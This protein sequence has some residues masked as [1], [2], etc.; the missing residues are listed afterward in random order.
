MAHR[1]P[2]YDGSTKPEQQ[3]K[4]DAVWTQANHR[5]AERLQQTSRA[6]SAAA[7]G[8]VHPWVPCRRRCN[9]GDSERVAC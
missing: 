9:A 1:V 4:D 3:A 5:W 6:R 7:P 8:T 2:R